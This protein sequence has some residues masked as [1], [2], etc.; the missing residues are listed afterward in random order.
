MEKNRVSFCRFEHSSATGKEMTLRSKEKTRNILSFFVFGF[1]SLAFTNCACA[2]AAEDILAGSTHPTSVV[3]SVD[4]VPYFV[5]CLI[6][7]AV[8]DQFSPL[9]RVIAASSLFTV[10]MILVAYAGLLELKLLGVGAVAAG[11]AFGDAGLLSMSAYYEEVT[12]RAYAAGSGAGSLVATVYYTGSVTWLQ[13]LKMKQVDCLRV[14]GE[15][16]CCNSEIMIKG[17]GTPWEQ[18]R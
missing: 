17:Q 3:F 14:C 6:L 5:G 16:H 8:L 2:L 18:E 7:P 11:G 12:S 13:C 10:G 1:I 9:V 15:T 4:I